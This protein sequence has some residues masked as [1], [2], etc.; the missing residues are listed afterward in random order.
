MNFDKFRLAGATKSGYAFRAVTEVTAGRENPC[1][2]LAITDAL[3][4]FFIVAINATERHFMAWCVSSG[5]HTA[6]HERIPHHSTMSMVAQAGQL[7][8]WPVSSTTGILTPVWA[9]AIYERENSGDSNICYVLEII[10][11]M[12]TPHSPYPLYT[13]LF[14]AVTRSDLSARPHRESVT[15]PDERTARRQ[16]AGRY[17]LCFAGRVPAQAVHHA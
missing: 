14:L 4:V 17:V 15:A 8:G 1:N 7:S 11:M 13:W 16:L 5:E 10:I 12:A 3:S 9:I 2:V 6:G